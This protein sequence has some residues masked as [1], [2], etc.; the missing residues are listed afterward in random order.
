M[1][2]GASP[3]IRAKRLRKNF[4][5]DDPRLPRTSHRWREVYSTRQ[6]VERCFSRLKGHRTLNN[7]CRRGL[8]K[9]GLHIALSLLALQATALVAA[10]AGNIRDVAVCTRKVA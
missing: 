7:H 2:I 4:G 3:V 6:A 5:V 8:A 9:I 1:A 10:V